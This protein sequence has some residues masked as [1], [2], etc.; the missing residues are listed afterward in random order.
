M[1]VVLLDTTVATL[2]HPRKKH[3]ELRAK[4]EKHMQGQTLALSFQTVAELWSWAEAR[5]WGEKARA[6]LDAFVRRFLVI[7]YNYDLAKT[8]AMVMD[9]SKKE[10]RRFEAGD[11]WIAATAVLH[12]L[13][14][15]AHDN[16]FVG[17]SIS[18]LKVISY[19]ESVE[20]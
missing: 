2:L 15:L 1:G 17:R 19:C 13:P 12:R 18:G 10:G 5:G 3:T 20:R 11:C 6:G 16:D 9:A 8:W 7:P 14:L 4:Y